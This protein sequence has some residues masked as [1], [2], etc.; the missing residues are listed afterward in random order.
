MGRGDVHRSEDIANV[1]H[2]VEVVAEAHRGALHSQD[3][4]GPRHK[5]PYIRQLDMSGGIRSPP[6]QGPDAL[7]DPI[8][9]DRL[10]ASDPLGGVTYHLS[11]LEH[12]I[13][14]RCRRSRREGLEDRGSTKEIEFYFDLL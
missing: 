3:V 9:V 12:R 5:D 7:V 6:H 1:L 11:R 4:L 8:I 10:A 14:M 2:L 13:D